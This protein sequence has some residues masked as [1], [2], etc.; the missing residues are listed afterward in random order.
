MAQ[1]KKLILFNVSGVITDVDKKPLK[2]HTVIAWD[3]DPNSSDDLLGQGKTNA[4]GAYSITYN[5]LLSRKEGKESGGP[6]LYIE[7]YD[8]IAFLGRTDFKSNS[9]AKE[10]IDLQVQENRY[11]VHGS[12]SFNNDKP[13]ICTNFELVHKGLSEEV[14]LARGKTDKYGNYQLRYTH[15]EAP[16]LMI[17]VAIPQSKPYESHILFNASEKEEM[18]VSI[19]HPVGWTEYQLIRQEITQHI[20][21]QKIE[22][23]PK[24][25]L[26]HLAH[27]LRLNVDVV[28]MY[29]A[30]AK[31][32]T[33]NLTVEALYGLFRMSFPQDLNKLSQVRSSSIREGITVAI[34]E[35]IISSYSEREIDRIVDALNRKSREVI[36]DKNIDIKNG[37]NQLL[38]PILKNK[39]QKEAFIDTYLKNED[40]PGGLWDKLRKQKEFSK[41]QSLV[42]QARIAF[43]FNQVIEQ[44]ELT[45]AILASNETLTDPV[46][47]VSFTKSIWK[48]RMIGV[49][50]KAFPNHIK[51]KD[52]DEKREN[53]AT[54]LSNT[55]NE[56]YPTPTFLDRLSKDET[57][58]F[59]VSQKDLTTF[60]NNNQ[61]FDLKSNSIQSRLENADFEEI[62]DKE[63]LIA[64]L[65]TIQRLG[66]FSKDY[67]GITS[68]LKNKIRS[69]SDI[70]LNYGNESFVEEYE[71]VLGRLEAEK[72]FQKAIK[73]DQYSTGIV[74]SIMLSTDIVPDA[75]IPSQLPANDTFRELFIGEGLCECKHCKSAYSP[76]SYLVD[77][78]HF[79]EENAPDAYDLLI[80]RRP[81]IIDTLLTCKN[82]NTPLPYID[83]INEFLEGL[84]TTGIASNQ[85][86]LE[87]EALEIYPEHVNEPAINKLKHADSNHFLHHLPIDLN[88]EEIKSYLNQ[89]GS[90]KVEL[91][92]L[93]TKNEAYENLEIV[94]EYLKISD[95]EFDIITHNISLISLG[96]ISEFQDITKLNL[97]EIK[98]L[99]RCNFINP[100][101]DISISE[102]GCDI[103]ELNF[104]S[105]SSSSERII[106]FLRLLKKTDWTIY[107]LD[108]VIE[109]VSLSSSINEA[110]IRHISNVARVSAVFDIDIPKSITLW[111]NIPTRNYIDPLNEENDIPSLFDTFFKNNIV[112]PI[113]PEFENPE[114]ISIE[115]LSHSSTIS[116]AFNLEVEDLEL[117]VAY[118]GL[119]SPNEDLT[120][121]SK[122]YRYS[123]LSRM[124]TLSVH[125]FLL[126]VQL[127]GDP[128]KDELNL[129]DF[130][131]SVKLITSSNTNSI[132]SFKELLEEN[133][134]IATNPQVSARVL[135][136][137]N[138]LNA[139]TIID[140]ESVEHVLYDVFIKSFTP[141][142]QIVF[143]S[144]ITNELKSLLQQ[145]DFLQSSDL[146]RLNHIEIYDGII[147]IDTRWKVFVRL[148]Q[149]FRLQE[150]DVDLLSENSTH[151]EISSEDWL[152]LTKR[153]PTSLDYLRIVRLKQLAK[154]ELI[155]NGNYNILKEII[156]TSN[157]QLARNLLKTKYDNDNWAEAVKPICNAMREKK[158]DALLEYLLYSQE[159][160]LIH[161]RNEHNINSSKELYEYLLIDVEMSACM[162]T[163][164]IKQCLSSVQ[165]FIQRLLMGFEADITINQKLAYQWNNWRKRYRVWEANRKIFLYP[166]NWIKP[167]L[168]EGKTPFFKELESSLLSNEINDEVAKDA[169]MN[170]LDQLDEVSNLEIVAILKDA[171]NEIL[172]A[173]G[174]TKSSPHVYYYRCRHKKKWLPW[175][176]ME[177][178]IE[179]DHLLLAVWNGR[180][181]FYW[182]TFQ[183]KQKESS[184]SFD[185]NTDESN[186][187]DSISSTND[188]QEYYLEM[189]LHWSE[190]K[191]NRWDG[192]K[193]SRRVELFGRDNKEA[194]A[195]TSKVNDKENHIRI[196]EINS[197]S[198]RTSIVIGYG[199]FR[200]S[201]CQDAPD[202]IIY[203]PDNNEYVYPIGQYDSGDYMSY[204]TQYKISGSSRL[205]LFEKGVFST[206]KDE[207]YNLTIDRIEFNPYTITSDL[208]EIEKSPSTFIFES[209]KYNLLVE[210]KQERSFDVGGVL[211]EVRLLLERS[212]LGNNTSADTRDQGNSDKESFQYFNYFFHFQNFYHPYVCDFIK[213]VRT[214]GLESLYSVELQKLS[215]G[216]SIFTND[217]YRPS[218][219]VYKPYP[220]EEVSFEIYNPF[221]TYNW[222]LFFHI[223]MLIA[224]SLSK[225]RKFEKARD[226]FHYIFDPTKSSDIINEGSTRFWIAK[227]F[228]D[229]IE[230]GVTSIFELLYDEA[231]SQKL[232]DQV[233]EWAND[234]FDPHSVARLRV[235]AY[236][237]YVIIK[238]IDNL[239]EWADDLYRQD[240][241]ESINEATQLYITISDILGKRKETLKSPKNQP[242]VS[243]STIKEALTDFGLAKVSVENELDISSLGTEVSFETLPLFCL[244]RNEKLNEYW[245]KIQQRL[246]NIRTCKNIDGEL[247]PLP[248]F[249]PPIDPSLLIKAKNTG[250]DIFDIATNQNSIPHYRFQSII[251]YCYRTINELIAIG[252]QLLSVIE[253]RDMEELSLLKQNNQK[254]LQDLVTEIKKKYIEEAKEN[255]IAAKRTH[256][257][258]T[259]RF[260]YYGKKEF[261][262]PSEAI[263]FQSNILA[264]MLTKAKA[265]LQSSASAAAYIPNVKTGAPTSVGLTYGGN[266]VAKGID[267]ASK[268]IESIALVNSL[269]GSYAEKM[270]SYSKRWDDWKHQEKT[271]SIEIKHADIQ[272][273][274]AEIRKEILVKDLE[275]HY[276]QIRQS[277]EINDYLREKY[278]NEELYRHMKEELSVLFF[279]CYK[280]A[281]SLA[282]K[283]EKCYQFEL[284]YDDQF[285]QFG[286]WNSIRKGLLCGEK[287]QRDLRRL[288][289][290]YLERNKR[291]YEITKTISLQQLD[292]FALLQFRSQGR[293]EFSLNEW[294]FDLDCPGH[295][296]RRIKTVSLTIP[297]IVG[298]NTSLNCK[299]TLIK[300]A[301]RKSDDHGNGYPENPVNGDERFV[302]YDTPKSIVTSNSLNDSG[303]FEVNL[304]DERYLP[305]EG[306]GVIGTWELE[307][308]E[309]R[310]V[311][312][313]K[314]ADVTLD[315]SYTA[316]EGGD[317]FKKEAIDHTNLLLASLENTP[318]FQLIDLKRDFAGE[319]NQFLSS[320]VDL[321]IG[322][323]KNHFPYLAQPK[324]IKVSEIKLISGL[325]PNKEMSLN[326]ALIDAMVN[327]DSSEK[328]SI[329][330]DGDI[331]IK[332]RNAEA[333][334]L[335]K[336][337]L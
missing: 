156:H 18:N 93:F 276:E 311:D 150:N 335:I 46:E 197:I 204:S 8:N 58:V 47:L 100:N 259:N 154:N 42:D 124:L 85:T 195:L 267:H 165:L 326:I 91:M 222:E 183:D 87:K 40:D 19:P 215:S 3:S 76:A 323:T 162:L 53:Y 179:G 25:K 143:S 269:I 201:N 73:A 265:K 71:G 164:R 113:E 228:R 280:E 226:W 240:T 131:E 31:E 105:S 224:T 123:L 245:D 310:Q 304:R 152:S 316:K 78:L 72:A 225:N 189:Q 126:S 256:D 268:S 294:L 337:S 247:R 90:S 233:E 325:D 174:R 282:Q 191:N 246:L 75:M 290:A 315:I 319:W 300:S 79:L 258:A 218:D 44:P 193:S 35:A 56:I 55:F 214:G 217:S 186:S 86:T 272:I 144:F 275:N 229:E 83:L 207:A 188:E 305:F 318:L 50:L 136:I 17:K 151:Y 295:Y 329:P 288:E 253:K 234:P 303:L 216:G 202:F 190:Y 34:N 64:E 62:E 250:F 279:E 181:F 235:T 178:D 313:H 81:D 61:D 199:F 15:D 94:K 95:E 184:L 284:G 299:A 163:S 177:L 80:S 324:R 43:Q 298:P 293:C 67:K 128:F 277:D 106:P 168:R 161:F 212:N 175:N 208:N 209:G 213:S 110:E 236:M 241:I 115:I 68:L 99:I 21:N 108:R 263:S 211:S 77:S 307:L 22:K 142:P 69:S 292:P 160:S 129:F 196:V 116:A 221:S 33:K 219:R 12:I 66:K 251:Q 32:A 96:R 112:G 103:D 194:I 38:D 289:Q 159:S 63:K 333:F 140:Q 264:K 57:E 153:D 297:A 262:Y 107:D 330:E 283:A 205:E 132:S 286:Y 252:N 5:P 270:G 243:F 109:S 242:E 146:S 320:D 291:E 328:I 198:N 170:Y 121:L 70:V 166:E 39:K 127:I 139:L 60:L 176:K 119:N 23:F 336:Y 29:S 327:G 220:R 147:E 135:E 227:P 28:E 274:A 287:L 45:N 261:M 16:D 49:N 230:N 158:R 278:S 149:V 141:I 117:L 306:Y 248:L 37:F 54:Y 239:M 301:Y 182:L 36:L 254:K 317:S 231:N 137:Q 130:V 65:L 285:I 308:T 41:N 89:L 30:A 157:T 59:K 120:S 114:S 281:F 14:R 134:E 314:I 98:R 133:Y 48:D 192:S 125:E 9:G 244:P 271:S 51:G 74:A 309:F 273:K 232:H 24:D 11:E 122:I 118:T 260:E 249:E 10:I 331:L 203:H 223:P 26:T 104:V 210:R 84:I 148:S 82:T 187:I 101:N 52:D 13:A 200:F 302:Y 334:L 145:P 1:S 4:K 185:I 321:K 206:K 257:I 6:D 138:E 169:I 296:R 97:D 172:H 88:S 155:K 255:I 171:D 111:K 7:V 312:Y 180:L 237:R 167:E 20:G 173:I 332:N 2:N 102:E 266:N 322:I 92:Q 27:K 238:Y